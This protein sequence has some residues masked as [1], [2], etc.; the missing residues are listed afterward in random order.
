[1]AK[2]RKSRHCAHERHLNTG[3]AAHSGLSLNTRHKNKDSLIGHYHHLSNPCSLPPYC[4][5]SALLSPHQEQGVGNILHLSK[6]RQKIFNPG[7]QMQ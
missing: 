3:Q 2:L 1:M 7:V 5:D 6:I 4:L